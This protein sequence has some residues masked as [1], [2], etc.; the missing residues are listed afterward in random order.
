M[1]DHAAFRDLL[2]SLAHDRARVLV[3]GT[4]AR[5]LYGEAA[6]VT[7]YVLWYDCDGDNAERVLRA[8]TRIGAP[9]DGVSA[10][11]LCSPDYAFRYGDGDGEIRLVGGM[12][13]VAFED[14]WETRLETHIENGTTLRVIGR[15]TLRALELAARVR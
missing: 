8:L 3:G 15:E 13:G 9:V 1:P 10:N 4:F 7:D 14:A 12:D 2:R 5:K 6:E 11:D